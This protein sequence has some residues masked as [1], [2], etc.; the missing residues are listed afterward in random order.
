MTATTRRQAAMVTARR[1]RQDDSFSRGRQQEGYR[2]GA[3]DD[4]KEDGLPKSTMQRGL[5][6]GGDRR[7]KAAA[8]DNEEAPGMTPGSR[9]QKGSRGNRFL[10]WRPDWGLIF[11]KINNIVC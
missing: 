7:A 1:T 3:G 5:L 2:A 11:K 8:D 4:N 10:F 6:Q 9:R